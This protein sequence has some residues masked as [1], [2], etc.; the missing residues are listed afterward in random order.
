MPYLTE[1]LWQKLPVKHSQLLH[2]AYAGTEPSIM[3]AAFPTGDVA[4]IDE[5][6]EAEMS[7]LTILISVVR[8]IRSEIDIK[9]SDR[10]PVLIGEWNA[11]V[12]TVYEA[13]RDQIAR[14]TH[15][16]QV[17]IATELVAPKAS[18]RAVLSSSGEVAIPLEGVIDFEKERARLSRKKDNLAREAATLE[19]QLANSD[20]VERAP[21]EKV[22]QLKARSADIALHIAA[23][24]RLLEALG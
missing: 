12:V 9:P 7:R 4:L 13:N 22:E 10:V 21:A 16:S 6:A 23:L 24:N 11:S 15:A 17:S 5:R 1:E 19:T 3:L 2:R 20:F 14:L 18:A 8:N